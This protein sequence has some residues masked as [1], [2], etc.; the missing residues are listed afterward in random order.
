MAEET[1]KPAVKKAAEGIDYSGR[2]FG[3]TIPDTQTA[4]ICEQDPVIREKLVADLKKSV[5]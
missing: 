5:F 3:Y 4:M 1:A 2:P